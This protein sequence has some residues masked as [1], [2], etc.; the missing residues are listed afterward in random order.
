[1]HRI[2]L[3]PHKIIF[4]LC[5]VI[6]I[7]IHNYPSQYYHN[8]TVKLSDPDLSKEKML[9][10][11]FSS[12]PNTPVKNLILKVFFHHLTLST[13]FNFLS[14]FILKHNLNVEFFLNLN[15][16]IKK[17]AKKLCFHHNKKLNQ[18][19]LLGKKF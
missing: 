8:Q 14:K 7:K 3:I 13:T 6:Y 17:K 19:L 15:L 11:F 10:K 18:H 1:M 5:K 12:N 4:H 9:V 2:F 16:N